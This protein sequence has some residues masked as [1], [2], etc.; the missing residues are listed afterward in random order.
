[1]RQK[2]FGRLSQ[3]VVC[4]GL[5]MLAGCSVS[6]LAK[7]TADFSSATSLVVDNTRNAY[8]TTVRLNE[9]AQASLLVA[10]YDSDQP[11]DP[12]SIRPLIDDKGIK[13]RTEVLEGLRVYAQSISD[14]AGGVTSKDLDKAAADCGTNIKSLGDALAA[15][16]PIGINITDAQANGTSTALKALGEFLVSRKIKSSVPKVLNDMDPSVDTLAKLLV[17]DL[18]ILRDQAGRDYEQIL[19]RQDSFIRHAQNGLSPIERRAEIR[20]L[21]RILARKK[22]TDDMLSDLQ[23]SI[24]KLAEAHHALAVAASSKD[25][26]SSLQSRLADLRASARELSAYYNSLSASETSSTQ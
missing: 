13:A 15:S 12:H 2:G 20:R 10:R 18:D 22:V 21:P 1:M 7:N 5:F 8:R 26:V 16:T 4:L 11:M 17:S 23:D 19:A 24:R 6:P 14:I 3:G 25:S 9:E